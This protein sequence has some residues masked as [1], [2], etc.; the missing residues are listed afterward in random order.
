M[1]LILPPPA[2]TNPAVRDRNRRRMHSNAG[3]PG[4]LTR[5]VPAASSEL[6]SPESAAGATF[7]PDGARADVEPTVALR[8]TSNGRS[9][10]R[11]CSTARRCN[12]GTC[13]RL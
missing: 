3:L 1:S 6:G 5:R 11:G 4:P 7:A 12:A 2:Q 10:Y 8:D 9:G 13:S